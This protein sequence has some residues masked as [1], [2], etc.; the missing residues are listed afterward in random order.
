MTLVLSGNREVQVETKSSSLRAAADLLFGKRQPAQ[1]I[2]HA[3]VAAVAAT[4]QKKPRILEA[5]V[6]P[7]PK[8][9]AAAANTNETEHEK[10]FRLVGEK[11]FEEAARI[12]ARLINSGNVTDFLIYGHTSEYRRAKLWFD[13][14]VKTTKRAV[15]TVV[16]TITPEVAQIIIANN[17][18]NRTVNAANLASIMRDV[19]DDRW[20]L[21]GSSIAVSRDGRNNDG[22]HRALGV[23]LTG[24][25]IKSVMTFGLQRESMKTVDIGRK[26]QAKDRLAIAGISDSIVAAAIA[27]MAFEIYNGR[28]PT[29]AE[30]DDYFH[31]NRDMIERANGL[32]GT[33]MKG[34]GPSAAGVATMHL[35]RLGY[36][37]QEIRQFFVDVRAGEGNGKNDPRRTL[38]RAIFDARHRQKLSRDDWFRALVNHFIALKEGRKPTEVQFSKSVPE[39]A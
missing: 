22:Q 35:L 33:N 32:T 15:A 2:D 13:D 21:N 10:V 4:T 38:Y 11:R 9:I 27:S 36:D 37:D 24:G 34:V 18:G 20:Q 5:V 1:P 6:A 17:D 7:A 28:K 29:A 3:V 30:A 23:L 19:A 14:M 8:P 31:A 26:R 16:H 25:S 12:A 39:I